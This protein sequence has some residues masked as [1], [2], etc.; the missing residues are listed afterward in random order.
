MTS[1]VEQFGAGT[2]VAMIEKNG[3]HDSDF[4]GVF[5]KSDGEGGYTFEKVMTGSTA[6]GGGFV[7]NPDATD[8]VLTAYRAKR[9]EVMDGITAARAARAERVPAIGKTVTFVEAITRGKNKTAAGA[10]GTVFYRDVNGY[11][12]MWRIKSGSRTY[13][14]GV[15][16][17]DGRKVF[18]PESKVRVTGF[19]DEDVPNMDSVVDYVV[20]A[21]WPAA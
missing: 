21:A 18:A 2:C 9:A 8:E 7:P 10:T 20:A 4:Y 13:R 12:P 3:Y 14:V 17:E 5:A 6:Y 16:F 1:Q 11:D 19:E 15:E